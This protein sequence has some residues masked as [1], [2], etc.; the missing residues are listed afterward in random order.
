MAGFLTK[1]L[2]IAV[3]IAETPAARLG[4]D[5]RGN[6]IQQ[7]T[8]PDTRVV[9]VIFAASDC[10]ISNRYVPEMKRLSQEFSA[11]HVAFW[12]A[13][14]NPGDTGDIVREHGRQYAIAENTI[15]DLDQTLARLAHAT[16][17]P[18]SAVFL[19]NDGQL[20]EVYHG[21]VDDRYLSIGEARPQPAHH[22]LEAAIESAIDGR[23]IANAVTR[24][25]GC[26]IVPIEAR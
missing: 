4:I 25:T 1:C 13:F 3:L 9:V 2:V 19:V 15:L 14:P 22:D 12:W 8:K 6:S 11:R 20:R 10:P 26:S 5:L 18:E 23:P 17:T 24:A 7:L 21:R 16:R